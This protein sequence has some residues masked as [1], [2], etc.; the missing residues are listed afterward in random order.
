[1]A[2]EYTYKIKRGRTI[3]FGYELCEDDPELLKPIPAELDALAQAL[4]YLK[5]GHPYR[6][7]A[8]WLSKKTGRS[9]SHVG[10]R[11]IA[12]K[13]KKTLD[14]RSAPAPEAASTEAQG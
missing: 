6:E 5:D 10:L 11:K 13:R 4:K 7:V 14:R 1:M 3:P 12:L 2:K 8:T 9:I